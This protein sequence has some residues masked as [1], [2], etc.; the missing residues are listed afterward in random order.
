MNIELFIPCFI[1]QLFPETAFNTIK[2][3]EKLVVLFN[4][5]P[6]KPAAVSRLLTL[7]FGMKQKRLV[8]N[9]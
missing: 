2:V 8:V 4:I 1:D 7:V 9:F 6:N 5:T 3:I